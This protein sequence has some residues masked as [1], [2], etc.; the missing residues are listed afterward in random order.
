[1]TSLFPFWSTGIDNLL[2]SAP[3]TTTAAKPPVEAVVRNHPLADLYKEMA[4]IYVPRDSWAGTRVP[5]LTNDPSNGLFCSF[6]RLRSHRRVIYWY[7]YIIYIKFVSQRQVWV[8]AVNLMHIVQHVYKI[9][10]LL[11]LLSAERSLCRRWVLVGKH[12]LT[13]SYI[14][15]AKC[16]TIVV[17]WT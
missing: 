5:H 2:S 9:Y 7:R 14:L 15:D 1:M 12:Q 6:D 10:E 3:V 11:N 8:V 13:Y 4:L 17:I 16:I